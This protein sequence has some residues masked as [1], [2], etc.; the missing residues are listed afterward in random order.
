MLYLVLIVD[1]ACLFALLWVRAARLL[2][3]VFGFA[4]GVYFR[5]FDVVVVVLVVLV[6]L[7]L[8]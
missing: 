5:V 6:L 2:A 8:Y 4:G 7:L 3:W 1:C